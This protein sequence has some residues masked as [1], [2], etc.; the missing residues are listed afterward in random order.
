MNKFFLIFLIICCILLSSCDNKSSSSL[1]TSSSI[2][3]VVIFEQTN[4]TT[5]MFETGYNDF[6]VDNE[7]EQDYSNIVCYTDFTEY[8]S[9]TE[10]III[11]ITNKNIGKGF[12]YNFIPYI[13]KKYNNEWIRLKYKSDIYNN[14][15]MTESNWWGYC[16]VEGDESIPYSCNITVKTNEF[17][18]Q[19]EEGEYRAVVFVGKEVIYAYFN[20]IN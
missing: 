8:P 12:Y 11:T 4:P 14:W 6:L 15:M 2:N 5:E 19:M 9:T 16:C 17:E 13:E 20:I 18:N 7:P 1:E 3:D 10:K